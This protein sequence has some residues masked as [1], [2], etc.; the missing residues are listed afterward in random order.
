MSALG[1][2]VPLAVNFSSQI[3]LDGSATP[4]VHAA[5]AAVAGDATPKREVK[6]MAAAVATNAVVFC[7]ARCM[8]LFPEDDI[9]P[10]AVAKR[11]G[12]GRSPISA[13]HP[14]Y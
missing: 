11:Q 7:A 10:D 14:R 3:V 2:K 9:V 1:V 13:E 5:G 8:R 12:Q 4:C 6:P